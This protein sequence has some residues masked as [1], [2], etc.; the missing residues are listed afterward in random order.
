MLVH[1]LLYFGDPDHRAVFDQGRSYTYQ[2]LRNLVRLCR[3]AL[4]AQGVRQRTPVAIFS[5]KSVHYIA[6][7][8]ALASLGAIA[9]PINSQ[10]SQRE[11]GFI[12]R[13]SEAK[14]LLTDTPFDWA[15]QEATCDLEGSLR[16]L[17]L[18]V[19]LENREP[20]APALPASFTDQEPFIIIYTSGTTGRPK[21]ALLSHANVTCNAWQFQQV[22]RITEDDRVLAVLPLYHCFCLITA[23]LNPLLV[24]ASI[25]LYDS[26]N[27]KDLAHFIR[28]M[29]LT[30]LY[31]VP[32]L[33]SLLIR[34]GQPEDLD[35]VR[36]T[37]LGGTAMP[38]SLLR[39]FEAKYHQPII[40]GYGLSEASPVVSVN[41]PER[42]KR[43]T[44][45]LPLPR[46]QVK[47]ADPS[48]R[49]VPRG[50]RGELLL[51][52]PN[53]ML[54]YWHLPEATADALVDGWLHTG[55]VVV[56]DQD[57]CLRIVDRL[58]D[59][60]ISMGENIYPR[61]I[62][63]LVYAYPG[64]DEAAVIGIP[65]KLRGQAGCC[66]YTVR[67][68]ETVDPRALKKYL[69]QNLAIYKVP[70]VFRQLEAMPHLATGKIAKKELR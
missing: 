22:L 59:M 26:V 43:G 25:Y 47:V 35:S 3:N 63:E 64:I 62:E 15:S 55:D 39:A 4:Y 56:E 18:E 17:P 16:Q 45:G 40:E 1:E 29:G 60:I 24:G 37:V 23:L 19:Y 51:K 38:L 61:E 34:R 8:L 48:G 53:V 68:G 36:Y 65:D 9:V 28:D 2:E 46:I 66:F 12:L 7:Y 69:Q 57:G 5:R 27:M 31:L 10:L 54:G 13:D 67:E 70:R 52:G 30:V 41:P 11:T 6:A 33:C 44:I 32:S 49:E 58:K 14:I 42:V 50:E 21:G 20:D